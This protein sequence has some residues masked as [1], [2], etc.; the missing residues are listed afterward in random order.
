MMLPI[1]KIFQG[2]TTIWIIY[3][4][5]CM[6]SLVEVY[7]AASYFAYDDGD[8]MGPLFKQAFFLAIG[9]VVTIVIHNIP[10]RFFK[11]L[12][13]FLWPLSLILLIIALTSDSS[14]NETGRWIVLIP[15]KLTFQPSELA[16]GAVILTVALIL[17]AMQREDGADR[18]A[19]KYILIV[20]GSV[21]LLIFTENLSTA[22]LLFLVVCTMM[23]IGRVRITQLLKLGLGLILTGLLAVGISWMSPKDSILYEK[24]F[25]RVETWSGRMQSFTE[26]QDA[27]EKTNENNGIKTKGS[28]EEVRDSRQADVAKIAIASS[29]Y[30]IG[31]MPGNSVERD[32]LYH[33][34]SDFI[35]AIIIEEL[36]LWGSGLIAL[37]YI[38][39]L[40]RAGRIA[41]RCERN[42]PAFLIMGLAIMLV[43][44]AC[45]NMMVAVGLFPVTG[46]P[47]PMI[48]RGGTS[49][50]ITCM[51]F[52]M[53]LSVS[54][55]ARKNK[56]EEASTLMA[57][58]KK[59]RK[60]SAVVED[61][62]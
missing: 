8:F 14:I 41:S 11:I 17:G 23:F 43:S 36:G 26:E 62:E 42:F 13:I 48:S 10:C 35:F 58:S 12:P 15:G 60:P 31:K 9:T 34:Y 44:Q 45:I 5:L 46:Q 38:I 54:R 4:L 18:K 59:R 47:L 33:A 61:A 52:G 7:S 1:K 51:Y 27:T 49:T 19:M 28:K 16:K 40:F 30:G 50:L 21:C 56:E 24:I 25:H 2:D 39:L 53:M 29:N 32:Y 6:I 37:F 22:A 3:F 55:Y 20:A 57:S